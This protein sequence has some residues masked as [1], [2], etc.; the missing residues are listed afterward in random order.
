MLEAFLSGRVRENLSG[1][2]PAARSRPGAR[3]RA[4]QKR[5]VLGIVLLALATP[6]AV[7]ARGARSTCLVHADGTVT[8][9]NGFSDAPLGEGGAFL[10]KDGVSAVL[11]RRSMGTST[12]YTFRKSEKAYVIVFED[13]RDGSADAPSETDEAR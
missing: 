2:P 12:G 9:E 5:L 13:G 3:Q 8:C 1:S 4:R 7:L 10:V 6:A 11:E